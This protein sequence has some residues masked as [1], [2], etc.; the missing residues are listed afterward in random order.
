MN[1]EQ[2]YVGNEEFS[3]EEILAKK[4]GLYGLK[5]EVE[6]P[7]PSSGE[8]MAKKSLEQILP[9][10]GGVERSPLEE[11]HEVEQPSKAPSPSRSPFEPLNQNDDFDDD[12]VVLMPLR[13]NIFN[14]YSLTSR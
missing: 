12:D 1:L 10:K 7:K 3:F 9:S 2:I 4:K 13:G 11:K 14:Q 8:I 6:R 5:F